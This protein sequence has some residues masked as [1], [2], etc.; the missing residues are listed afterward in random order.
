[1]GNLTCGGSISFTLSASNGAGYCPS[2]ASCTS[3]FTVAL[4]VMPPVITLT[5]SNCNLQCN[6]TAAQ[7]AA[8][9]GSATATDNCGS[10]TPTFTDGPE[11]I[12]GCIHSVTRTWNAV[13]ACGNNATPVSR[14]ATWTI[15]TAP[16]F[17]NCEDGTTDL[18]CNPAVLPGCD[19]TITASNECGNVPVICSAGPVTNVGS[20]GRQQIFTYTATACGGTS[21]C[22]RTY[23][24]TVVTAPVFTNCNNT[25]PLGLNP[26]TL[27][28]CGN[29]ATFGGV[30]TATSCGQSVTVSCSA[31][32]VT[33]VGNCGKQQVFTFT[34]TACGVTSTCTRT[35]TWS[36]TCNHIFPTATTCCSYT[37]GSSPLLLQLCYKSANNKVKNAIPG[38]MFYYGTVTAPITGSFTIDVKQTNSNSNFNLLNIQNTANIRLF[39]ANCGTNISY[40][41]SLQSGGKDARIVVTGYTPGATYIVSVKYDVKSMQGSTSTGNPTVLYTYECKINGTVVPD[42]TGTIPAVHNCQDN[43]PPTPAC[44]LPAAPGVPANNLITGRPVIENNVTNSKEGVSV[45]AYPNPFEDNVRFSINSDISGRATLEVYSLLGVKLQ[46]VYTGYV[47]AGK[48]Q[49]INYQVPDL[50]RTTLIYKLMVGGK[51]VTGKLINVK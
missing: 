42:Q 3:T 9:L 27:P 49:T 40:T 45:T 2:T 24:W 17:D 20:C 39:T 12:N 34:A 37:S 32:P 50:Y 35:Y 41:A 33:N 28:T 19:N 16:V 46:T 8:C 36:V 15:V 25:I 43:T 26:T 5:P 38:V 47:F 1:L 11:Q 10:V 51:T 6:P 31:G 29:Y 21:T 13:D 22:T 44:T 30:V 23:T 18:G 4:D 48:G 14:T 7:I